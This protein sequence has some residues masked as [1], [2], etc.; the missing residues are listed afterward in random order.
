MG[1][2][3]KGKELGVG[4]SQRKDGLY[5]ARY[6]NRDGKRKQKY[7]KKLGD[8]RQW[9]ADA[10]YE[11]EHC[12]IWAGKD[13]AVDAWFE[14]WVNNVK[15]RSAR[16]STVTRYINTYHYRIS[17][18][19]GKLLVQ[20]V[21]PLHCQEVLNRMADDGLKTA[22]ITNTKAI[23]S[24]LFN[25]AVD[26]GLAKKNPVT[27]SMT[28]KGAESS[29]RE[30]LTRE[31]QRQFLEAS[32]ER[33]Y[34]PQY[35]FVLQTGIRVGELI[36]LTWDDI[37]LSNRELSVTK[38]MYCL[39]GEW[40]VGD[41]KT[42]SGRRTI[43]LTDE[44]IRIL[45]LAATKRRDRKVTQMQFG[46]LVFTTRNGRPISADVYDKSM[47]SICANAGMRPITMHILRHTFATRCIEAG[48][49]PKTLQV[50]LGHASIS[51]TMDIY[52]HVME[53]EKQNAMASIQQS[54][55]V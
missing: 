28:S 51:T 53:D 55:V 44:A 8:C 9:L 50:L 5:T 10:I 19:I 35:A 34:Y 52:V 43:P 40:I 20:D 14:Y 32:A 23:M 4:I 15:A 18:I 25:G 31:E 46:N 12:N 30:G 17:P 33:A 27:R 37:D 3:V 41:T 54:L 24:E 7:F 13:M 36:A 22:S 16:P 49:N 29:K 39:H 45:N 42:A 38:T 11:D 6:T 21:L 1:K 48:M 26:N 2:D 47:Y